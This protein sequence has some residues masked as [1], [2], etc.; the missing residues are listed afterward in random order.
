[1]ESMKLEV[2]AV[3]VSIYQDII[4]EILNNHMKLNIN[5]T[6]VFSYLIKKELSLPKKIYNANNTQDII[7]K[8]LSQLSGDFE[9]YCSSIEY[10]IKAIHLLKE[11][12][13]VNI[14]D[15]WILKTSDSIFPKTI[16]KESNFIKKAIEASK[17]MSDKQFMK[18]VISN[19]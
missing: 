16:Y 11:S 8:C 2:E 12:G 3:Q 7:Y 4:L 14:S 13:K 18:E 17:N 6:I 15:E 9:E 1:M 10:I 19:V 5:K